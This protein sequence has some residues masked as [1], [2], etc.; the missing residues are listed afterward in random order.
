MK[1]KRNNFLILLLVVSVALNTWF[2]YTSSTKKTSQEEIIGNKKE[3]PLLSKRIFVEDPNDVI[4]NFIP[5]R[6]A[7]REYVS[8]QNGKVGIY[9][10]YLPSGIS[11]GVNEKEEVPIASLS[12]VPIAMS[13]MKKVEQGTIALTDILTIEKK[14]LDSK[15]GTLWKKGE[16]ATFSVEEL[17]T[18]SL[19]ESDNTANDLLFSQLTPTEIN[20]VYENFDI[21]V[22]TK[23]T[24][25][26]ISPKSYSSIFRS[27]F[28]SSFLS[29]E[30]SSY[31]LDILT[32]TAFNDKIPAGIPP[33][34]RV[35]HKIGIFQRIDNK[36]NVFTDCGIVYVPKR[37]Y[38]L[39]IFVETSDE[40][41][42]RKHMSYLSNMIYQYITIVRTE[43]VKPSLKQ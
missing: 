25:Q 40:N 23:D 32:R 31:I 35:A 15:F 26:K 27:L 11:I 42:A 39:C 36:Q 37:Q 43:S 8:E 6:Q 18:F 2:A 14:H 5:L 24:I 1:M 21:D 16:G 33:S 9:F 10:E 28:L 22:N 20:A 41:E 17:V 34:V 19:V 29:E 4:L 38:V 12:K 30:H 7:L 3:F 13:I